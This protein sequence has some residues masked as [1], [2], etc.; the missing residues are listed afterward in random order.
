MRGRGMRGCNGV[1][2]HRTGGRRHTG[3][4]AGTLEV[5]RTEGLQ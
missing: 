4:A 2:A 5:G 1:A 3:E